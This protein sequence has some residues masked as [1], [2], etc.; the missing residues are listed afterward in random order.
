M[1]VRAGELRPV[2]QR[3]FDEIADLT[4]DESTGDNTALSL[5]DFTAW[6]DGGNDCVAI[7]F[8]LTEKEIVGWEYGSLMDERLVLGPRRA[9][10]EF[11]SRRLD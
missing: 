1:D 3:H 10:F 4:C 9:E 11:V 2:F 5:G 6:T 8:E 7:N